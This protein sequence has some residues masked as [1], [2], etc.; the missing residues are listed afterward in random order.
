MF[1]AL[2]GR[3][4]FLFTPP[5]LPEELTQ[6]LDLCLEAG[7]QLLISLWSLRPLQDS[8]VEEQSRVVL[9]S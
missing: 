2:G 4:V 9:S 6:K 3:S 8:L 5:P 1:P 7:D